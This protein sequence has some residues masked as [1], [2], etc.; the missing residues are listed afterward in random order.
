[1]GLLIDRIMAEADALI[2]ERL[3]GFATADVSAI[4]KWL[5]S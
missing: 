1:L 4:G 3:A 5:I 2:S